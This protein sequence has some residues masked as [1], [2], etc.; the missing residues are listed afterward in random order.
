MFDRNILVD[1]TSP[2]ISYQGQ[3]NEISKNANPSFTPF[4]NTLNALQFGSG[5][6]TFNF[7]G[8]YGFH[9]I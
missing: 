9:V 1:D 2:L 5:S 8:K 6:F 3:W 7:I 4:N